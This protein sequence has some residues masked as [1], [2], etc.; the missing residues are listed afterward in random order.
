MSQP[1]E[2]MI[3]SPAAWCGRSWEGLVD[4]RHAAFQ[5][6]LALRSANVAN[7]SQVVTEFLAFF[8]ETGIGLFRNE[9]E[10]IFSELRPTPRA[11]L[12][13]LEDH[14]EISGL[15]RVLL[16]D[17]QMDQVALGVIQLLG[18]LLEAH[19][20]FEE[21]EIRPLLRGDRPTLQPVR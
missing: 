8:D 7:S 2:R 20:L 19:L 10:W 14:I 21:E 15:I 6:A 18:E 17:A 1:L 4:R 16:S 11:V 9:E 5:Q 3:P 13:A 12:R